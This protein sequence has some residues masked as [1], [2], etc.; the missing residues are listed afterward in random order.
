LMFIMAAA[1]FL[2]TSAFGF[3]SW[4]AA[5]IV[6][7]R[8]RADRGGAK[9]RALAGHPRQAGGV[10][11]REAGRGA[12]IR[13]ARRRR[14]GWGGGG[15]MRPLWVCCECTDL[16]SRAGYPRRWEGWRWVQSRPRGG[17][18][19]SSA[20]ATVRAQGS[21]VTVWPGQPRRRSPTHRSRA[22]RRRD[23]GRW[24]ARCLPPLTR[25]ASFSTGR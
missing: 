3:T 10:L 18:L 23:S 5:A 6:S 21:R 1:P 13:T 25:T 7:L 2:T 12:D 19:H 4:A 20:H 22:R 14:G 15:S 11:Q 16:L 17:R 9:V 24:V 8:V